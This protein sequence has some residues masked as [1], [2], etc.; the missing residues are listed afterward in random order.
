MMGNQI[1]DLL[2][3]LPCNKEEPL[4]GGNAERALWQSARGRGGN[5]RGE[6][7]EWDGSLVAFQNSRETQLVL[8]FKTGV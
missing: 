3:D 7:G 6:V 1:S 2:R 4:W 8:D 5:Y